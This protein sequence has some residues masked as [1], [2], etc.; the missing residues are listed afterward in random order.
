M[1]PRD[2]AR[3]ARRRTNRCHSAPPP[4]PLRCLPAAVRAV[5]RAPAGSRGSLR[6]RRS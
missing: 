1:S 5:S 6:P 2:A 4:T 3:H